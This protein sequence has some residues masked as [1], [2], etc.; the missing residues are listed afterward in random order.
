MM[1]DQIGAAIAKT[2]PGS[3]EKLI[4]SGDTWIVE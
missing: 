4:N 1:V 2:G 3:L